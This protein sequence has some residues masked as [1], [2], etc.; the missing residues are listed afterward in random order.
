MMF[1][2]LN[3]FH[4]FAEE[5]LTTTQSWDVNK[6]GQNGSTLEGYSEGK[7]QQG[8]YP[9]EQSQ[10]GLSMVEAIR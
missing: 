1:K 3:V 9:I 8:N 10:V 7:K 2:R 6:D 4:V 5:L